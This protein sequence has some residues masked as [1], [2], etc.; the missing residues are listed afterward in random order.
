MTIEPIR[1]LKQINPPTNWF[2]GSCIECSE[3][4]NGASGYADLDGESFTDYYCTECA[5]KLSDSGK[6]EIV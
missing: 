1:R 5:R 3:R 6:A 4:V 2:C